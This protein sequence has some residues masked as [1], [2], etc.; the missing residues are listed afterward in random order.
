MPSD[1]MGVRIAR[2]VSGCENVHALS[3]TFSR[4]QLCPD[5]LTMDL[6]FSSDDLQLAAKLLLALLSATIVA[7][8]LYSVLKTDE[9]AAVPFTVPA[10]EQFKPGWQGEVLDEPSIKVSGSNIIRCYAP[11]TGQL[12]GLV[13]PVTP[14]GID[15][16][17]AKAATA[18]TGWA[19]STFAQ[20]RR[21]LKT[22][23]SYV[24]DEQES[25]ARA[26]CLDS[27]KTRV[28]AL[29]GEVLVTVEK[30]KWTI[31]HGEKALQAERR[32]TNLLMFYKK[33][34]VWYEPLGVVAACVSWK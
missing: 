24:L 30:L 20:R 13:N 8:L 15:R 1:A 10:P 11:A 6:P 23:L 21:L 29:F 28:D 34:E 31:H 12:L 26:A 18:Q 5:L 9:E 22:L 4:P 32:P 16:A 27:G 14:D 3:A 33:N 7:W 17:I 19:K 25:I 2:A